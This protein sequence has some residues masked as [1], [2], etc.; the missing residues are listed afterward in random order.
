[1]VIDAGGER[2]AGAS[3][4][5]LLGV[6]RGDL[7]QLGAPIETDALG[8][9]LVFRDGHIR[10]LEIAGHGAS[11][12]QVVLTAPAAG[13]SGTRPLAMAFLAAGADQVI[14]SVRPVTAVAAARLAERLYRAD[15]IDLARALARV[16]AEADG[17]GDGNDWLGFAAFGRATCN[18]QP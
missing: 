5:A 12:A 10:A 2:S 11:A 7:L 14:A 18:P 3:R 1:V 15:P 9:A 4:S 6:A 17:T 16:Q 8:D 13:P